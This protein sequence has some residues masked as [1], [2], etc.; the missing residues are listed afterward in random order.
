MIWFDFDPCCFRLCERTVY[1]RCYDQIFL[2]K[3]KMC[4]VGWS[5]S[6]VS[7][8][9]KILHARQYLWHDFR[10]RSI[11]GNGMKYFLQER[12]FHNK[13]C[14]G[15]IKVCQRRNFMTRKV[16]LL[17]NFSM[18]WIPTTWERL[19]TSSEWENINYKIMRKQF[20][21]SSPWEHSRIAGACPGFLYAYL[22]LSRC[23]QADRC[24]SEAPCRW[25]QFACLC[26]DD[27]LEEFVSQELG[28]LIYRPK[29][30][31]LMKSTWNGK[32][33]YFQFYLPCSYLPIICLIPQ[34]RFYFHSVDHQA[35]VAA[36]P[37]L[38]NL[39]GIKE[40]ENIFE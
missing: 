9:W 2:L 25:S 3:Q 17:K 11:E 33:P 26:F 22:V 40:N 14:S 15:S 7:V 39:G 16:F 32:I 38:S 36:A 23:Q 19:P 24:T 6:Y 35:V 30:R 31:S 28:Q 34:G 29:M 27:C 5:L 10:L 13:A 12:M 18:F 21:I 1:S 4:T 20:T 8:Y 37:S